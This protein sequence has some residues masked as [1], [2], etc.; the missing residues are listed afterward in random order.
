[1]SLWTK[2][3]VAGT[4]WLAGGAVVAVPVA[5]QA[6]AASGVVVVRAGGPLLNGCGQIVGAVVRRPDAVPAAAGEAA[7]G[8]WLRNRF[9][10]EMNASTVET[11][12]PRAPAPPPAVPPDPSAVPSDPPAVP[13]APA[14]PAAEVPPAPG[15]TPSAESE[16]IP[17]PEPQTPEPQ[18]PAP[19]PQTPAPEP[20]TSEPQT[21]PPAPQ[22]TEEA[23][24]LSQEE[25][26]LIELGLEA[27]GIDPGEVDGQF[28]SATR[29]AIRQWQT[30]GGAEPTGYLDGPARLAL[31]KLGRLQEALASAERQVRYVRWTAVAAVGATAVVL[32]LWAVGRRSAA[33]VE[34]ARVGAETLARAGQPA[35]IDRSAHD[36][37]AG[38]APA[39]LL[40][41]AVEEGEPLALRVPG[42]AVSGAGGAVVGRSP[43]DSTVVLDHVDVSRRHF[44]LVAAGGSV[45]IEDL[46]SMNGTKLNGVALAPGRST[47]LPSGAVLHV[48]SL[49]FTVTLQA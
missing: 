31:L 42:S 37:P 18:T 49:E 4:V 33:K 32:L 34:L 12:C 29:E 26:R 8:A 21:P 47:P 15:R 39:V 14:T 46:N 2:L 27:A 13:P 19:E 6:P 36:G 45:L 40:D 43:F 48:G 5:G 41:G 44:R 30:A 1:M 28:D 35:A 9:G 20:Q 7:P 38:A 16:S 17:A 3:R 10:D 24:G 25:R 22:A 11:P 23:L